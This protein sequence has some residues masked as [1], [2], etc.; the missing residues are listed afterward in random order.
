MRRV[1]LVDDNPQVR[2]SLCEVFKRE[3]DFDVCGEAE[4]GREAIDQAN[5]LHPDLIVMDLS[6]PVLNGLEAV[7]LLKDLMPKVPVIIYTSHS[8]Q[9]VETE[10]HAAGAA[11]TVSKSESIAVLVRTIRSLLDEIAA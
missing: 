4:N 1:L 2:Q 8:G 3:A 5:S 9:F 7:R 6:M 11:A 10:A